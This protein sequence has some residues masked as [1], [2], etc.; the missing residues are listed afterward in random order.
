MWNVEDAMQSLQ[1][2]QQLL[3]HCAA[4]RLSI[5]MR[6]GGVLVVLM[7]ARQNDGQH[8]ASCCRLIAGYYL[9]LCNLSC[10]PAPPAGS[11]LASTGPVQLL[12]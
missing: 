12:L 10:E 1:Q 9:H 8:L 2:R 11:W 6:R 5:Q 7:Q 3:G 4:G